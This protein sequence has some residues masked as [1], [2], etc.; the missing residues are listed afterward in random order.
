MGNVAE[1]RPVTMSKPR[2]PIRRSGD[3]FQIDLGKNEAQIVLSLIRQLRGLLTDDGHSEEAGQL[4][5][6][7][8]PIA[9]PDDADEE[10]EY[11]RLMRAD[12]VQ[13]KLASIAIVEDA[14]EGTGIVSED[15]LMAFMQAVN[16]LRLVLGAIVGITNDQPDEEAENDES[17]S[18]EY[19]LYQYLS[20]ILEQ[21]VEAVTN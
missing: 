19:D 11:Q 14:L 18:Q 4:L 9:Y 16:S 17:E 2:D 3:S 1:G 8:F 6:R 20:W 13:S 10:D 12:L 21:S 7:L 5:K 15:R